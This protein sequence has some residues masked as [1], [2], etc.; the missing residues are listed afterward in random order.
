[1]SEFKDFL[2]T[3][4]L[5][6][7]TGGV[8]ELYWVSLFAKLS[9]QIFDAGELF[10]LLQV[11]NEDEEVEWRVETNQN[12]NEDDASHIFLVDHAWTY[13]TD[14]AR[15][16]LAQVPGLANRMGRLMDINMEEEKDL[17]DEGLVEMIMSAKWT[18]SQTYSIGSAGSVEERQPVWLVSILA[19]WGGVPSCVYL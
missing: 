17:P 15:Q 11:E 10:S 14:Q 3:H 7:E 18:F 2:A 8:P 4:K 1:V 12:I 19:W 5:Q 13:K 9:K 6:L 16:Q